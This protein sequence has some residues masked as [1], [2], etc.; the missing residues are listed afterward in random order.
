LGVEHGQGFTG[1]WVLGRDA[2][3]AKGWNLPSIHSGAE[4]IQVWKLYSIDNS[5]MWIGLHKN[6]TGQFVWSD[7]TPVD[8]TNWYHS[9]YT[10]YNCAYMSY[11]GKWYTAPCN[12]NYKYVC[13]FK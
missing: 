5:D 1:G 10:G 6:S 2:C 13:V 9:G 3:T 12:N 4:N 11:L 7:G 8:Y